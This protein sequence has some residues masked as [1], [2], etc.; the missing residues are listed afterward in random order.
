MS[1]K[2]TLIC[3]SLTTLLV[4]VSVMKNDKISFSNITNPRENLKSDVQ[5]LSEHIE[6]TDAEKTTEESPIDTHEK[7]RDA[8]DH[9]N[10]SKYDVLPISDPTIGL[11]SRTEENSNVYVDNLDSKF[12]Q[13]SYDVEWA[14]A[15]ENQTWEEFIN[16]G[17]P[18]S[19]LINVQCRTTLCKIIVEHIDQHVEED[20]LQTLYRNI[21]GRNG[22]L[23]NTFD[24]NGKHLTLIYRFR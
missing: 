13:E 8:A 15:I 3:I 22:Y 14:P 20:F 21:N 10:T 7:D 17:T 2:I 19:E 5:I 4:I 23:H 18:G 1:F 11:S 16:N 6:T 9:E 12:E 24:D